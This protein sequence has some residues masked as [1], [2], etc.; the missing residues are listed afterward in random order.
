MAGL[1]LLGARRLPVWQSSVAAEPPRAVLTVCE[2]S[3]ARGCRYVSGA[4]RCREL[5]KAPARWSRVASDRSDPRPL[6]ERRTGVGFRCCQPWHCSWGLYGGP[7]VGLGDARGQGTAAWNGN[8]HARFLDESFPFAG[9]PAGHLLVRRGSRRWVGMR[10]IGPCQ[11]FPPALDWRMACSKLTGPAPRTMGHVKV[12][13][14]YSRW[15]VGGV[16]GAQTT[17]RPTAMGLVA[18][19]LC[20]VSEGGRPW[21]RHGGSRKAAA[22]RRTATALSRVSC[23]PCEIRPTILFFGNSARQPPF[24]IV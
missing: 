23:R 13:A 4:S 17:K 15:C 18:E 9:G 14:P 22:G 10:R 21:H 3:Q 8:V 11:P 16:A 12:H 19:D 20:G 7:K 2:D 6:Q 24:R 5:A 1:R